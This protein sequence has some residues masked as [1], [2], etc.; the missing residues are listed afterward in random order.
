MNFCNVGFPISDL[1]FEGVD[2]EIGIHFSIDMKT[3]V[4]A[5]HAIDFSNRTSHRDS[6]E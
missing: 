6:A 5:Y 2:S 3:Y 4:E 1:I